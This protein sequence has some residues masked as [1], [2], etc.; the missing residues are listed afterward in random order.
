MRLRKRKFLIKFLPDP[1][2]ET[3]NSINRSLLCSPLLCAGLDSVEIKN[4]SEFLENM[5][6]VVPNLCHKHDTIHLQITCFYLQSTKATIL[7]I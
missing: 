4:E 3:I 7:Q 6:P 5:S 1:Q 2:V